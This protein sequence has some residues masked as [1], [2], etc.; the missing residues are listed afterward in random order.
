MTIDIDAMHR[1]IQRRLAICSPD[2][3]RVI[4]LVLLHAELARTARA[5][6][7]LLEIGGDYSSTEKAYRRGHNDAMRSESPQITLWR[8]RVLLATRAADV[9]RGLAEIAEKGE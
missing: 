4:D 8:M 5:D 3:V 9:E 6:P 2:E 1:D 7:P